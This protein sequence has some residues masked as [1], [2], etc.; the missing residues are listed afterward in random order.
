[1]PPEPRP[2]RST[3]PLPPALAP[4]VPSPSARPARLT[5]RVVAVVLLLPVWPWAWGQARVEAP[6]PAPL[7]LRPSLAIGPT[8][9]DRSQQP[10]QLSGER[11]YG[12]PDLD[13]VVEGAAVLRKGDTEIQADRLEYYEP[14]D[15]ARARGAVRVQ[16]AGDVYEGPLLELRVDAFEGFFLQ[17]R[18]RF[19]RNGAHGEAERV[20]FIDENRVRIRNASMTTCRR[21]PG[22]EWLPDWVLRAASIRL[23]QEEETGQAEDAVLSFKGAPLLAVPYLSFP[24]SDRRKSGFLPPTPGLDSVNGVELGLPYY[25]NIAPNRDA[26]LTPVLMSKRGVNLATEFRYLEADYNGQARLDLMPSDSLRDSARW[27]LSASHQATLRQPW[28]DAAMALGLSLNRVS[29]D[30]YW[31]DFTRSTP[32]LTQRLLAN[33]LT[34][35][36]SQGPFSSSLRVLK[37]QTLQDVSSPITPPYDRLPQLATRFSRQQANGLDWTLDLDYTRFRSDP[38]LTGQPDGQ[39]AVAALQVARP[40]R[41]PF[42]FITPRLQWHLTQYALDTPLADGSL[43]ASRSVPTF[44]LDAGLAFERDTVL[45]G[46][47]LT[48]TLEPRVFYVNTPYRDQSLLPNYDSGANDFSFATIYTENAFVGNDRLSDSHLLTLGLSSRLLDPASGAEA[49]RLGIAQRLRYRDQNVTLP[50][51]TP[52]LDRFSDILLGAAVNWS[53]NWALDATVQ[54]NPKTEESV[55][56]V[57]G[58][59]YQ[60]GPYRVLSAAYRFQRDQSEQIDIG[61]QWPLAGGAAGPVAGGGLGSQRWYSVGRLNYSLVDSKLVDTVLGFEYDADC[62]LGRVVLERL[63]TG[64]SS[65]SS[66]IMFQL[67]FVGFTRLGANPL[68]TLRN[69]V[70]GYRLLREAGGGSAAA[71]AL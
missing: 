38:L 43:S 42:G 65:A 22:P 47:T 66:R 39:R 7:G 1:M 4:F 32:S 11:L 20:D 62:W 25:W 10:V 23:D 21:L 29:D 6:Q 59:R 50:G 54:F 13:T 30:N 48:Q 55:R 70:P 64:T 5:R 58:G 34:L 9:V 40:W 2:A 51:G 41:F 68:Q 52:A 36:G 28:N 60:P 37:W 15:L 67:E 24:L 46:R 63:Q 12:R 56:A 69:N 14:D 19:E 57:L 17:P 8:A 44:S 31:R 53:P 35:S 49:A 16:R 27:G 45:A 71:Q 61:W 26:T 33:D 3:R 18:Y